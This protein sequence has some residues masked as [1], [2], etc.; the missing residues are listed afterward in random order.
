VNGSARPGT[1][2]RTRGPNRRVRWVAAA[3]AAATAALGLGAISQFSSPGSP[4]HDDITTVGAS[5]GRDLYTTYDAIARAKKIPNDQGPAPECAGTPVSKAGTRAATKDRRGAGT[6]AGRHE[7]HGKHSAG[8][9]SRGTTR[10]GM[11]AKCHQDM[12]GPVYDDFVDIR[13]VAPNVRKPAVQQGASTGTFT[14]ECGVNAE[15]RHNSDNVIV[16]PGVVN[17]AHHVHD[18]VGNTT[19]SGASTNESLAAGGTTCDGDDRSTYYW[20][21]L[22]QRNTIG[23]DAN[24]DGGGKDG[25]VGRILTAKSATITFRGSPVAEVVPMPRFLR[26]I[27]GDAKAFTNGPANANAKWSCSGFEDRVLADKYPLCPRG[28]QVLRIS[29]FQSCWDGRNI[30]SE[31][32]RSHIVFQLPDNSG[33]CPMNTVAVPQLSITLAYDVPA[34]RSFAVDGFPEQLHK[35]VTDHN[36]FINVMTDGLMAFATECI[37]SGRTCDAGQFEGDAATAGARTVDCPGVRGRLGDVPARAA[38]EVNRNLDLLDRQI[39]EADRRLGTARGEGGPD[40][41]RNA[42]LGPLTDKRTATLDRI[43]I[44]IGRTGADRPNL[45]GLAPC[46]LRSA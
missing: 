5:Q 18:Y 28:S 39:A 38:D 22:R 24:E 4:V 30:D 31:N 40:F 43:A 26:I 23:P 35:P 36:D 34:G 33:R 19:T 13:R 46:S 10:A 2:R 9:R 20:P 42:V 32:H 29:D 37:N 7:G 45:R 25:N 44:A 12:G 15:G 17:G 11:P 3:T 27:T 6:A 8:V 21:V 14:V 1:D 41:V 16:A